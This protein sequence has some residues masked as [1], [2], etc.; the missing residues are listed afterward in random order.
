[1][2]QISDALLVG[3]CGARQ[4][5]H[6]HNTRVHIHRLSITFYHQ[7]KG[8]ER[9]GEEKEGKEWTE[10]DQVLDKCASKNNG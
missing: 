7:G 5:Y 10:P 4:N 2:A 6:L 1:M 8:R 3:M 9:G